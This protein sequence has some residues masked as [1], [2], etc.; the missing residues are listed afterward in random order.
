MCRVCEKVNYSIEWPYSDHI[1]HI[2]RG[3]NT[4]GMEESEKQQAE[5]GGVI[6]SVP[7]VW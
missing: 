6:T 3:A 5:Q 7:A 1:A 4:R 2:V